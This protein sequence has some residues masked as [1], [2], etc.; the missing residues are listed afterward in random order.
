MPALKRTDIGVAMGVSGTDVAKDSA[1]IILTDDNFGTKSQA[2]RE[3]RRIYDNI[4]KS[5]FFLLPTSFSK[6]LIIAFTTMMQ[7][8][9]PLQATQLLWINM[10]S[11]ITIQFAFIFEPAE[12]GIMTRK[13]RKTGNKLMSR[14]DVW[15]M[16]YVSVLMAVI[17]L[18]AHDWLL[19]QGVSEAV[20]STV[21]VNTVVLS[22]VFYLFNIRTSESAFSKVSFTNPKA[23]LIISVIVILQ[24]LLTYVPFMQGA[25]STESIS[26]V[27]WLIAISAGIIVLLV[28]ELDK[29]F[30]KNKTNS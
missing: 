26:L 21:M 6:G 11:A 8:E 22:K 20:A 9:L 16:A 13:P 14:Q 2:I 17:S 12:L 15:Q 29:Y 30:R 18:F 10:V 25:F 19:G 27:G 5:I 23:F 4:K 1:D 7:K 3:G 24:L 28:T